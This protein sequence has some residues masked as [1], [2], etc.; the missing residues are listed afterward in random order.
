MLA[1]IILTTALLAY[2]IVITY[3]VVIISKENLEFKKELNRLIKAL[4]E[5]NK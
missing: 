4:E 1:L 3:A 5:Q 2:C